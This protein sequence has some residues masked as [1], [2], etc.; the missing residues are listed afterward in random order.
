MGGEMRRE[1]LKELRVEGGFKVRRGTLS[2]SPAPGWDRHTPGATPPRRT[3][4]GPSRLPRAPRRAT[5]AHFGLSP[6]AEPGAGGRGPSGLADQPVL[7]LLPLH[8]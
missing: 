5:P 7:F 2:L 1:G 4:G 3:V 6:A 8:W